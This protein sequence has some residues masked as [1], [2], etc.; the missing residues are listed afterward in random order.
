MDTEENKL[1]VAFESKKV[2]YEQSELDELQLAYACTIHKSQ[3]SEFPVVIMPVSTA[4]Y[5][6]LQRNLIYT[7]LTR[8]KKLCILIGTTQALSVAV[9]NNTVPLRNSL[10]K[11]RMIAAS[12][13]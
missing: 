6:M 1:T 11:E 4:H 5:I 8:A 2:V 13:N 10:L 3:G 12:S 9:K 7:G